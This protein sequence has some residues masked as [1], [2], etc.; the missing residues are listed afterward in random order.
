[1]DMFRPIRRDWRARLAWATW[2]LSIGLSSTGLLLLALSYRT[3]VIMDWG[4]R[5]MYAILTVPYATVGA[6]VAS[7]RPNHRIGW[8]F[9]AVG[10]VA[11]L[12]TF[13][14]EYAVVALLAWPGTLPG[15]LIAAWVGSWLWLPMVGLAGTFLLLLFPTGRLLSP[16]WRLVA[17]ASVGSL[18]LV[19]IQFALTPGR[20]WNF[21]FANNPFGVE[22]VAGV[23][24]PVSTV[25]VLLSIV[26]DLLPAA[27][28]IV[29]FHVSRGDERQQLKWFT[30]A[31]VLVGLFGSLSIVSVAVPLAIAAQVGIPLAVGIALFKY[32]LYDI[33]LIVR[34]T[35]AYGVLSAAL[36]LVYFGSV[37]LFQ[38]LFGKLI[39]EGNMLAVT[40]STLAIA[41]LFHPLR[42][43][44]QAF[45]DRTFYRRKYDA[46]RVLVAF[47][48]TLR[49]DVELDRL[50]DTLLM[51]IE[52]TM[53]P[54][55]A[56]LWLRGANSKQGLGDETD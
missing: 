19:W 16:R 23:L 53:Q 35:L 31:A 26:T 6:A 37:V 34:R 30:Y 5:G 10:L 43:R 18:V 47:S 55:R 32:R 49:E 28:V 20:M 41:A 25:I 9:C 27:S 52:E 8:L 50:S 15:G 17:W 2:L 13:L 48:T 36:V 46:T 39:A 56:S 44:I 33:D 1:M 11:G 45:I 4:F 51:V 54:T 14:S 24:E 21:S 42:R 29:R 12:L 40:A 22:A 38:S 3:P 7:R